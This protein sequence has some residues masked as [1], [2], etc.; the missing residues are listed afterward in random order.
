M[1][2]KAD[3]GAVVA[4]TSRLIS[5]LAAVVLMPP[6]T[7]GVLPEDRADALY[8][9][10]DGGGVEVTGPSILVRKGDNK[11]FSVSANYYADSISSASI[12]VVT[13]GSPYSEQR[14]QKSV[15]VDF[16]H[17]DT[18]MSAGYTNSEESDY[19]A[20]TATFSI[21]QSMFG[22]LTTV[23][24]GFS[25][26]WDDVMDNT[27]PGFKEPADHRQYKVALSQ[28]LT[29]NLIMAV[30]YDAV[31]D[32]GF[33]N[34][35][36]RSVRY[37]DTTN[38]TSLTTGTQSE[39][40]PETRTSNAIAAQIKYYLPYRA[41]IGA[42][43][44]FYTDDWN[45]EAHTAEIEYTHPLG[46]K[47]I[48]DIGYRYYTQSNAD[49][50]SDLFPRQSAQNFLARD[51]ELSEFTDHSVMVGVG[52]EFLSHGWHFFDRASLNLNYRHVWFNYDNF[53]DLE[54]TQGKPP[55]EEPLYSFTA[56]I[57]QIFL[58]AWF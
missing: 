23:T 43:Y 26:G 17:A 1:A 14:T 3:Q 35:P 49:F 55:G 48:F 18:I 40:Y 39:A 4:A 10:Y 11:H 20:N 51:K 42:G 9:S 47:W 57:Y 45:I 28:V 22:D 7:A 24:L 19:K 33:L 58:S 15:S 21:T 41:T 54:N 13:Q 31:T 25:R 50:Y 56:G 36:Y 46:D 32:E 37:I 5:F 52:Y 16:L 38:T 44:R 2:Q 6:A 53:R 12:D 30:N 29:K 8:H 34:N 27:V